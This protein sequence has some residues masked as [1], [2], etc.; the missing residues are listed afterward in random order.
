MR[1]N[2]RGLGLVLGV[3]VLLGLVGTLRAQEAF[4]TEL[5]KSESRIKSSWYKRLPFFG[6]KKDGDKKAAGLG[7]S[8]PV[9][10]EIP[11]PANLPEG[12]FVVKSI[13]FTGDLDFWN[14]LKSDV[15]GVKT[16][17]EQLQKE[18]TGKVLSVKELSEYCRE[19][20]KIEIIENRKFFLAYLSPKLRG[21]DEYRGDGVVTIDVRTARFG[22]TALYEKKTSAESAVERY[23]GF[24]FSS[25]QIMDRLSFEKGQPFNYEQFYGDV[26]SLNSMPD[27][28]LDGDLKVTEDE[29]G[30]RWVNTDFYVEEKMPLHATLQFDNTGTETTDEWGTSATIQYLN[31]TRHYDVLSLDA[32]YSLDDSLYS[33]AGSYY[34]PFDVLGKG[35]S[36][37][38]FGGYSEL[39][40]E[41][42]TSGVD[43]ES[44]GWFYGLQY[45]TDMIAIGRY[46][47]EFVLEQTTRYTENQILAGGMAFPTDLTIAPVTVGVNYSETET[48]YIGGRNFASYRLAMNYDGWL[49]SDGD[50]EFN[51]ARIGAEADYMIHRIQ[52][53]RIQ[54][55][56]GRDGKWLLY[57]KGTAQFADGPLAPSEQMALGG[58]DTVRGYEERVVLGD[59]GYIVN[60]ELRTPLFDR[61]LFGFNAEKKP[62]ETVQLVAFCD[63]GY[64]KRKEALPGEFDDVQ[65]LGA[66]LGVRISLGQ[67]VQMR[68]DY[69]FALND[70]DDETGQNT[71]DGRFHLALQMQF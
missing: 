71:D 27:L 47:T 50:K 36:I 30:Q 34:L 26:F 7:K 5:Q 69:G 6:E 45:Q 24:F 43:L 33:G 37:T 59:E 66:G 55:L 4:G 61:G 29:Q 52:A 11:M 39:D 32:S 17:S 60:V 12:Q 9:P 64:L 14:S 62:L 20:T 68:A 35:M 10:A 42:I 28:S 46:K 15:K 53:A 3:V 25:K 2:K 38:L 51:A 58:M 48:D 70:I 40:V 57:V 31:L 13:V 16:L 44:E 8:A 18:L 23:K 22:D 67:Y 54:R 21:I 19:F 49:T 63:Y 56:F 1:Q 65:L 41:D